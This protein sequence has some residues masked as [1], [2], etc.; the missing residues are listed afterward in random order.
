M[1]TSKKRTAKQAAPGRRRGG[2]P[3]P[4][5]EQVEPSQ[6][7]VANFLVERHGEELLH[8]ID[9]GKGGRGHAWFVWTGTGWVR[10]HND[11]KA[12]R[13]VVQVGIE[14]RKHAAQ[15][16]KANAEDPAAK[17]LHRQAVAL[18]SNSGVEGVL[19]AAQ[20]LR[21]PKSLDDWDT[22][23]FALACSNG[24]LFLSDRKPFYEFVKWDDIDRHEC[25]MMRNTGVEF[26]PLATHALWDNAIETFLPDE[27]IQEY[28]GGVVCTSLIDGN[29]D[30]VMV[31]LLGPRNSGK[32]A[33]A[34]A[35]MSALGRGEMGYGGP[36]DA[37]VLRGGG[38][39]PS[40][41]KAMIMR[42]RIGVASELDRQ[43]TVHGD[44]VKSLTGSDPTVYHGKYK[45]GKERVPDFL[46]V[47][48]ANSGLK[49]KGAD[50]AVRGRLIA[51][52]FDS[53]QP[54]KD[55][56]PKQLQDD[57]AARKAVLAWLV[58]CWVAR[59][60]DGLPEMPAAV[61]RKTRELFEGASLVTQFIGDC[62]QVDPEMS[63]RFAERDDDL[64][65]TFRDYMD[66]SE[67]R[68]EDRLDRQTFLKEL[69]GL[70]YRSN[71]S[72][73]VRGTN[74]KP[75]RARCG[76]RLKGEKSS[77]VKARVTARYGR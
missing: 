6:I 52:P 59:Q 49:I 17:A 2:D 61:E 13:W 66:G 18:R 36:L 54:H 7:G 43:Q 1:A 72:R 38:S 14:M 45:S 28:L 21:D 63:T 57:P 65:E 31:F 60:R 50:D 30:G 32:S 34:N 47:A 27:E 48:S 8:V 64:W 22:N 29:P 25:L 24:V 74:G 77:A 35:I 20:R 19:K 10:D 9:G 5:I 37:S 41:P 12:Y 3:P 67:V 44:V 73:N 26:D 40:E 58:G 23:G 46:P 51:I 11:T 68:R 56:R 62:C 42:K 75:T 71:T 33:V 69:L 55:G 76:L 15:L 4:K 70:G 16:F 53:P 39:G